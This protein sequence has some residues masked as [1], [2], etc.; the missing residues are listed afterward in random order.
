MASPGR[1]A[2]FQRIDPDRLGDVFELLRAEV[3]DREIEPAF[4]LAVGVFRQTNPARVANTFEPRGDIDAV[5]HEVAVALL[6]H[7]ADAKLDVPLGRGAGVA[8]DH[9]VLHFD[10]V[11]H[12]VDALRNSMRLPSPVRLTMR[13]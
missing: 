1:V 13:P 4:D 5:A 3:G 2:G 6:D 8:L 7:V 11:P 10:R 9:A 12:R